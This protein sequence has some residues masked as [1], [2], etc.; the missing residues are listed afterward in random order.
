MHLPTAVAGIALTY[1]TIPEGWVSRIFANVGIKI[2]YTWIGITVALVFIGIPFV[3]Q[4]Y[5]RFLKRLKKSMREAAAMF[6]A[7]VLYL[8][9]VIFLKPSGTYSRFYHGFCEVYR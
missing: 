3:C 2:A 7:S 1:L 5:S 6:G 8:F 9:S 4:V